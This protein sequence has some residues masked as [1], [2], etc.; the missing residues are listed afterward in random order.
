M[1]PISS[2]L[3]APSRSF[4]L[5]IK[6]VLLPVMMVVLTTQT[7][8]AGSATWDLDPNNGD[9]NRAANWTPN[10]VPNGPADIAALATSNKTA[11]SLSASVEVSEILF[12]S[13]ANAYTIRTPANETLS[14][15]G[16]GIMNSSGV[17]QGFI[18]DQSVSNAFYGGKVV[19]LNGAR[20]GNRI[21][22]SVVAGQVGEYSD[23]SGTMEFYD[24]SSA[25]HAILKIFGATKFG[26]ESGMISFLGSSTAAGGRF[27]VHAGENGGA[28]AT[29]HFF[30]QSTAANAIL[31]NYGGLGFGDTATAGRSRISN[32]GRLTFNDRASA[33]QAV[34]NNNCDGSGDYYYNGS[35]NFWQSATAGA[36]TIINHGGA[37]L[38]ALGGNTDF[39][40]TSTAEDALLIAQG[41]INGGAG[42]SITFSLQVSDTPTAGNATL[43][44]R[45]GV[46]GGTGGLNPIWA[47][48]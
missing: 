26:S 1:N 48:K 41:G 45:P 2:S 42:A 14:I 20:A 9:W 44:A 29:L 11:V 38:G 28:E 40:F 46:G 8:R 47:N 12:S 25:D 23:H 15:S 17:T 32:D 10:V 33:D 37:S 36:A 27:F 22:F 5:T 6:A 30:R 13:G 34:I 31:T 19:F 3:G 7:I 24:R 43:I 21:V 39:S 18:A 4:Q 16:P 35:I